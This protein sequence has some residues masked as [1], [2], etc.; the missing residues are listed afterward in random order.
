MCLCKTKGVGNINMCKFAGNCEILSS[1]PK[2]DPS[3]TLPVSIES[4]RT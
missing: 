2:K 4:H 3:D 1:M